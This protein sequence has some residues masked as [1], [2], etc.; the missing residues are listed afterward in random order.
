MTVLSLFDG[1]SCGQIALERAGVPVDAYYASEIK[2]HAIKV[3]QHNY[4]N[5]IQLGDVT[6]IKASDLPKIDLLMGGSPCQDFSQANVS[7]T[8]LQGD[9]S[10]LFYEYLRLLEE[11]KPTYFLLENVRMKQEWKHDISSMLGVE[12]V[13]IDSKSVSAQSRK[14]LYWTNI[15]GEGMNG[16]IVPPLDKHVTMND[17]VD[18]FYPKEK[19]HT[20]M[21][22][23]GYCWSG[24]PVKM[25]HRFYIKSFGN[26]VFE[27]EQ[28]WL[29]CKHDY[30]SRYDGVAS[31]VDADNASHV[32]DNIRLVNRRECEL[33][34]TVPEGYT[35]SVTSSN[36]INLLGDGWTVDVI[37]HIFKGLR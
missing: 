12:P 25:F 30:D 16:E 33:M 19:G 14:R 36:A 35:D 3:T 5:T 34:Q 18:G 15:P 1:M 31:H 27:S 7:V 26:V 10:R 17:I 21:A 28:H 8:G 6:K 9:K 13:Y 20:L 23:D 2:K 29:D 11:L 32:Y 24:R 37:A 4:P 22:R